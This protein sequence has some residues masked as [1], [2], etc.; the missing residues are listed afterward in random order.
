MT[1]SNRTSSFQF[2]YSIQLKILNNVYILSVY[3]IQK[4]MNILKTTTYRQNTQNIIAVKLQHT[5]TPVRA[6]AV[7]LS[8]VDL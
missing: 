6:F 8:P 1:M 3:N 2:L 4:I 7:Y 5:E